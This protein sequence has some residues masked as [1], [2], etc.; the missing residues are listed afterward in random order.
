MWLCCAKSEEHPNDPGPTG[1]PQLLSQS[2]DAGVTNSV[3]H[4]WKN[5][6]VLAAKNEEMV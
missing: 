1:G 3:D 5:A 2:N 4:G 6:D